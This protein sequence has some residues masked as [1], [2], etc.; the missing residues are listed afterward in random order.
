MWQMSW[1]GG[2]RGLS[3]QVVE[4]QLYQLHKGMG[5]QLLQSRSWFGTVCTPPLPPKKTQETHVFFHIYL[6]W[7][8][9]FTHICQNLRLQWVGFFLLVLCTPCLIQTVSRNTTN[10]I[11]EFVHFC[12]LFRCKHD[13]WCHG[14]HVQGPKHTWDALRPGG[15]LCSPY[16]VL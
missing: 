1:V 14:V 12:S 15:L 13:I 2:G 7:L 8:N 3:H 5:M 4:I 11:W 10:K 9:F 16:M 6:Y